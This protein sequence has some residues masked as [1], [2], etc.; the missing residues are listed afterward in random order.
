MTTHVDLP[1]AALQVQ[2]AKSDLA[3]SR[4][5]LAPQQVW[6]TFIE[7]GGA[8]LRA[9]HGRIASAARYCG[10]RRQT[11]WR[12]FF[13]PGYHCPAW[14][15]L[16]LMAWFTEQTGKAP[17]VLV[18]PQADSVSGSG[19]IARRLVSPQADS[20]RVQY[21]HADNVVPEPGDNAVQRRLL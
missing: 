13:G 5:S 12:W 10:V 15:V 19:D 7:R 14:A 1:A 16:P 3:P 20:A 11:L 4:N 6:I 8:Y 18:S 9:R 21:R 2:H 17:I